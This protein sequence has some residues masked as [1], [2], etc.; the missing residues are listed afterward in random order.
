M[1]NRVLIRIKVIQLLYSYLL[2]DNNFALSE[3]PVHPTKEKR[4]AFKSYIDILVVFLRIARSI[5]K[6]GGEKP[7]MSNRFI[8]II[9]ADDRLVSEQAR[10]SAEGFAFDPAVPSLVKSVKESGIYKKYIKQASHTLADDVRLWQELYDMVILRDQEFLAIMSRLENYTIRAFDR[11][12]ELLAETFQRFLTS[13]GILSDAKKQLAASMEKARELYF[14]L[15]YLPVEITRMRDL[16][17]DEARHKHLPTEEDLNPNLRFVENSLVELLAGNDE[18]NSYVEKNKISW[19]QENPQFVAKMLNIIMSSDL[20]KDYMSLPVTDLKADCELW[21]SILKNLILPSED[22]LEEMEE[23]SIFWND[24]L[25]IISTFVLKTLRRVSDGDTSDFI[26]PK[27]KDRED[28]EFGSR[29]FEAVVSEKERYRAMIDECIRKE[30]W[31]T[32]RLAFMD[33]VIIMTAVA[34]MLNFPKI[35]LK[36]T[37]NEYIEMAKSYSTSKSGVFVNG[38]LAELVSHLKKEGIL[39]KAE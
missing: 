1:I 11:T 9:A 31:D 20:Y 12:N 13:S 23:K 22:F 7:L 21:R 26:M 37:I 30:L 18:L 17:I 15:L 29:L 19:A 24:D 38:I 25:E 3:T 10:M 27:Y 39:Q 32:E 8:R 34:E 33:A 14:R 5:E 6:R 2:I 35:P 28:E 36:V 16:Q 4:F